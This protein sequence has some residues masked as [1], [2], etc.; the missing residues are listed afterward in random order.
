MNKMI[1]DLQQDILKTDCDIVNTLR[2]AHLIAKK[3]KANEF[4]AWIQNELNGYEPSS[5]DIP[6]YR[7]IQGMV[8]SK[9][10]INGWIPVIIEDQEIENMLTHRL[11]FQSVGDLV[12]FSEKDEALFIAF[13]GGISQHI[14]ELAGYPYVFESALFITKEALL[15]VIEKIKNQLW[16]WTLKID[17][18]EMGEFDM[19]SQPKLFELIDKIPEV[20]KAFTTP[21]TKGFPQIENIYSQPVFIDWSEEVKVELRKLKQDELVE[22]TIT[23]F[24][25]FTGWT[26][27]RLFNELASKLKSI[28]NNYDNYIVVDTEQQANATVPTQSVTNIYFQG[29]MTGSNIATGNN[30]EQEYKAAPNENKSWFEKYWFPLL[31]TLIGVAGTIIAAIITMGGN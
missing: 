29:N 9:N 15:G 3:L 22:E 13:P 21:D 8:K 24:D 14:A 12:Q 20:K 30:S 28:K 7:N 11:L 19:N 27:K 26:D 4:D 25:K 31:L 6:E 5:N 2:K 17:Q 23:L 1:S 10:P 16:E 18:G